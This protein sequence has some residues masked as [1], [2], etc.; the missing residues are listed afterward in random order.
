MHQ[1]DRVLRQFRFRQSI[2]VTP[3]VLDDEHKT[4]LR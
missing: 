4:G 3:E 1:T 2:P